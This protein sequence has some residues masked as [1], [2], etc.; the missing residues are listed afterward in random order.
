ME[1]ATQSPAHL[2]SGGKDVQNELGLFS[3][4]SVLEILRMIL[5]E[6]L[7]L[8]CSQ[9]LLGSSSLGATAHCAPSG[10]RTTTRANFAAWRLLVFPDSSITWVQCLLVRK[11]DHAA[12][13]FID[14]SRYL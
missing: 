13:R 11:A 12:L 6:L 5:A 3:S 1:F 10:F 8:R 14:G 9:S 2:I 4:D 7:W